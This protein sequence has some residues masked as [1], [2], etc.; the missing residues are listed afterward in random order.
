MTGTRICQILVFAWMCACLRGAITCRA[1]ALEELVQELEAYEQLYENL[2][3][4]LRYE[5]RSFSEPWQGQL[6]SGGTVLSTASEVCEIHGVMQQGMFRIDVDAQAVVGPERKQ[7]RQRSSRRFDGAISRVWMQDMNVANIIDEPSYER[8]PIRP[9]MLLY[10]SQSLPFSLSTYLRGRAAIDATPGYKHRGPYPVVEITGTEERE[11]LACHVVTLRFIPEGAAAPSRWQRLWLAID[12]NLIP[13]R[14]EHFVPKVSATQPDSIGTV[15]AWAE[16]EPGLWFPTRVHDTLYNRQILKATGRQEPGWESTI[17]VAQV[18]L[19]P[20]YPLS[21]F[22]TLELPDGTYV[23][24]VR[25]KKI[26]RS[27]IQNAP[28]SGTAGDAS[29]SS[30]PYWLWFCVAAFALSGCLFLVWKLS[31]R[32]RMA[33]TAQA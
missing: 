15:Q 21:F 2:E 33:E 19:D 18:D 28:G 32:K 26:I 25:Q 22:N 5:Y 12:R 23:Y 31:I 10:T 17:T 29:G 4:R 14:H 24:H 16:V 20:E 9:H 30:R 11:G 3:V 27:Y 13:V 6:F 1:L 8:F 7:D